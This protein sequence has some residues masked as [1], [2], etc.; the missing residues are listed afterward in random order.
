MAR[1]LNEWRHPGE[2]EPVSMALP[3]VERVQNLDSFWVLGKRVAA[4]RG[5][6]CRVKNEGKGV[7]KRYD[8]HHGKN[9]ERTCED[10]K[11]EMMNG[12]RGV[13][14]DFSLRP[15]PLRVQVTMR[16]MIGLVVKTRHDRVNE[17]FITQHPSELKSLALWGRRPVIQLYLTIGFHV[18]ATVPLGL[19][20]S[21]SRLIDIFGNI[22]AAARMS[23][24]RKGE[25]RKPGTRA[26][27][28]HR[29][30]SM[31]AVFGDLTIQSSFPFCANFLP[32]HRHLLPHCWTR[33]PENELKEVVNASWPSR[34]AIKSS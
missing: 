10:S 23:R 27:A 26:T 13:S 19:G 28:D 3:V 4:G 7:R 8:T 17:K 12:V 14:I 30:L 34:M 33:I 11:R 1:K 21:P 18:A 16:I 5:L 20:V 31:S 15:N 6:G 25:H 9:K 29:V 2:A 24:A 32:G 22:Q